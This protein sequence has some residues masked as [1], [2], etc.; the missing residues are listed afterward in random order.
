MCIYRIYRNL[1]NKKICNIHFLVFELQKEIDCALQETDIYKK[2]KKWENVAEYVLNSVEGWK[3]TG[4]RIRAGAQEIDLSVANISLDDEL[5]QMGAYI[6]I[7][8]K[9]W[10]KQCGHS[11]N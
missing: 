4:K 1:S 6:L 2:G 7:E 11:T 3:I 8:C 9:N 5:W 10:K